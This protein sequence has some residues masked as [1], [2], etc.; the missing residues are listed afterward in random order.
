MEKEKL[1]IT[2][3]HYADVARLGAEENAI[4]R[5]MA[6]KPAGEVALIERFA[7]SEGIP[8]GQAVKEFYGAR[9]DPFMSQFAPGAKIDRSALKKDLAKYGIVLPE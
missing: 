6:N 2:K 5:I 1:G 4:K 7:A 9:K 3:Q 8:F